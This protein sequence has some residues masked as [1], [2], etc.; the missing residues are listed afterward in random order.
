MMRS[1]ATRKRDTCPCGGETYVGCCEPLHRGER[2]AADAE[3][4][5]RSRYSA[6]ARG[7]AEYLYITL[8]S[9]HDDRETPRAEWLRKFAE[10]QDASIY[11]GLRIVQTQPPGE[12]GVA[13]VLFTVRT[14]EKGKNASFSELSYFAREDGA[15][16][17]ITGVIAGGKSELT[18]A[19]L[20]DI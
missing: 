20:E 5:M 14:R 7:E 13:K 16:R 12:D 4:L 9:S 19:A 11:R 15:W 8:H 10:T 2:I 17:Y 6:F 1:M 3:E 18:I